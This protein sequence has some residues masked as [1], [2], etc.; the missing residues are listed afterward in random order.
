MAK[1]ALNFDDNTSKEELQKVKLEPL[2]PTKL[3]TA[4]PH[5]TVDA[6]IA[7]VS[8]PKNSK[9]NFFDGEITDG[10]TITRIVGFDK[11]QRDTLDHFRQK[12]VPVTLKN[13][14]VQLSKF[15]NKYEVVLKG[16]TEIEQSA[17]HFQVENLDTLG[18]KCIPLS[19]LP[20]KKEYD[21]VTVKVKVIDVHDPEKVGKNKRKQ[22]VSISDATGVATLTLWEDDINKVELE[23]SY[24]MNRL[25]V[26]SYRGKKQLSL[27]QNGAK[28]TKI[29]DIGDV[30]D[31]SDELDPVDTTM[32]SVKVI[33]VQLLGKIYTC[34]YC[35]KANLDQNG[36]KFGTCPNCKVVQLLTIPKLTAKLFLE[37]QDAQ[38]EHTTVRAYD[39]LLEEIAQS[40]EVTSIKLLDAPPFDTRYNEYHVVTSVT[41]Q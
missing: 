3:A 23:E 41:R 29:E 16:Y 33:G 8:P 13:C 34:Q 26:R 6:V 35:K 9:T 4:D 19:E 27:P 10:E 31:D 1:R 11:T 38:Q 7:S 30:Q 25:C 24:Q 22:D 12:G 2:T 39:K 28:I 40:K 17:V 15:S 20:S 37:T 14:L 32:K 18:S 5:A 36:D 21:R